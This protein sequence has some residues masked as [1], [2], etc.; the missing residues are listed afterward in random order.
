LATTDGL[1]SLAA[2]SA[3]HLDGGQGNLLLNRRQQPFSL[4]HDETRATAYATDQDP[5]GVH[6][7]G[8][9]IQRRIWAQ[10]DQITEMLLASAILK[11]GLGGDGHGG[12]RSAEEVGDVAL[13]TAHD[14]LVGVPSAL[15][16]AT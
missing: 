3:L 8:A 10:E 16:R 2:R 14:L 1:T 9:L 6:C 13:Q 11:S 15:R 12:R 5:T 7:S 4:S